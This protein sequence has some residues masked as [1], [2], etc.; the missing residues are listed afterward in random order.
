MRS[1][2]IGNPSGA[3]ARMALVDRVGAVSSHVY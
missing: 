1:R 3:N 2:C